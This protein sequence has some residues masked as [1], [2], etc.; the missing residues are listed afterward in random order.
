MGALD[1]VPELLMRRRFE[2]LYGAGLAHLAVLLLSLA[3]A[4]YAASIVAGDPLWPWMAV[5]FVAGVVGHDGLLSPL[6][7]AADAVLRRLPRAHA[8]AINYIRLPA[9]GA[10]LTFLMFLPGIIRQGEPVVRGQTGFD[11]APFL[12]RWLLLVAGMAAVSA[13]VHGVR[14]LTRR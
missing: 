8:T 7:A 2:G 12:G 1:R 5:W 14:R 10:A 3:V 6:A 4:T 13:L 11:Q 9:L